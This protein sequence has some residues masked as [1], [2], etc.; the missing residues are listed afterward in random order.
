MELDK[1]IIEKNLFNIEKNFTRLQNSKYKILIHK[2][3]L[4]I[5]K[6]LKNKNK[7]MFC[8]N[9]GS[10]ADSEHICTELV[11]R[12]LKNRKPYAAISLTT[13]T[14][15]L[16]AISNDF[17]FNQIFS[18]QIQSLGKKNDILFAITTSGK[19]KN[20]LNAID[21]AKKHKIKIILL[22]SQKALNLKK[23]SDILIPVPSSRV[24]RIQE[25]HIAEGHI[26]CELVES[27]IN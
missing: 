22:T 4:L 11:G 13:N 18:K 21:M 12:Y 16:S 3:A 23:K 10:A 25:M 20:I 1:K 5:I 24:D 15:L 17:S 7:V 26:I 14:S 9:G 8:G 2:A 19:S 6:A 27:C